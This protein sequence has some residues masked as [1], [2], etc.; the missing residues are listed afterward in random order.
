[1]SVDNTHTH[2]FVAPIER[3]NVLEQIQVDNTLPT[4]IDYRPSGSDELLPSFDSSA[5]S[6]GVRTSTPNGTEHRTPIFRGFYESG[7][8]DTSQTS[9]GE[10]VPP[11]HEVVNPE[12]ATQTDFPTEPAFRPSWLFNLERARSLKRL[13]KK[14]LQYGAV[15]KLGKIP[16]GVQNKP[17]GE[18]S[19][20]TNAPHLSISPQNA[21][22][23]HPARKTLVISSQEAVSIRP[24]KKT[25]VNAVETQTDW[26][27]SASVGVQTNQPISS[28]TVG[29]QTHQFMKP[30]LSTSV[31]P[32]ISIPPRAKASWRWKPS[33]AAFKFSDFKV[34]QK[35]SAV[36]KEQ[37]RKTVSPTTSTLALKRSVLEKK[38][39]TKLSPEKNIKLKRKRRGWANV[40]SPSFPIRSASDLEL[41]DDTP[42]VGK[43]ELG[44]G[45]RVKK[46][47]KTMETYVSE[48]RRDVENREHK[49]K[50][51]SS[52]KAGQKRIMEGSKQ[53]RKAKKP[54]ME[55]IVPI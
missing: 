16:A 32:N 44:K 9:R 40:D 27:N 30:K 49:A 8:D 11:T 47:T 54:K 6:E 41:G 15:R 20:Q 42:A 43:I 19:T 34:R 2:E 3:E 18:A 24:K 28:S 45:K 50:W 22:S 37:Q 1:M 5:I 29:V 12:I 17:V 51:I 10:V 31:Q 26:T 14:P 52:T 7:L 21:V 4:Q 53:V 13:K 55:T 46:M 39:P 38:P 23:I 35:K 36:V 48:R 33:T 25:R